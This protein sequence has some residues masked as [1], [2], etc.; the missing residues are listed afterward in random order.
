MDLRRLVYLCLLGIKGNKVSL[1]YGV[2]VNFLLEEIRV[3]D[4]VLVV[5]LARGP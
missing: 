3:Y 1:L 2:I 4:N 5:C